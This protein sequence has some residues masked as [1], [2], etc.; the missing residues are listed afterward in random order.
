MIFWSFISA[1]LIALFWTI[2]YFVTGSVPVT[3]KIQFA[4]NLTLNLPFNISRW[5][6]ILLG[7]FFSLYLV[8]LWPPTEEKGYAVAVAIVGVI[9]GMVMGPGFLSYG[10]VPL[11]LNMIF[12][13]GIYGGFEI[14]FEGEE[15][16]AISAMASIFYLMTVG[17]IMGL[18]D[19]LPTILILILLT[20]MIA[21]L[22][23]KPNTNK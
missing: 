18:A 15:R 23:R 14:L 9:I 22:I 2:W 10:G 4:K 1:G 19:M 12:V 16:Q 7:P 5:W 6:D 13:F 8:Y 21:L 11:L 17:L 3:N 20:Y